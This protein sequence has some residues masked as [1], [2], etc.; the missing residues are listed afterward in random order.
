MLQY[1]EKV[2]KIIKT[3]VYFITVIFGSY[4]FEPWHCN[5]F[6]NFKYYPFTAD[7]KK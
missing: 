7:R 5:S 3:K 1:G 2:I 6:G 4:N